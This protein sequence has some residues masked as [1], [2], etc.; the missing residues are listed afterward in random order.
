M[1]VGHFL[2]VVSAGLCALLWQ[3]TPCGWAELAGACCS[4]RV[5]PEGGRGW[6]GHSMVVGLIPRA[7]RDGQC[8]LLC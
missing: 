4:S 3:F 1:A 2:R 8:V 5:L 7:G 6:L